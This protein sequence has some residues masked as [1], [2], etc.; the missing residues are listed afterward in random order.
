MAISS[1][2]V[3]RAFKIQS[4]SVDLLSGSLKIDYLKFSNQPTDYPISLINIS[5]EFHIKAYPETSSLFGVFKSGSTEQVTQNNP[6][7]IAPT[8]SRDVVVRVVANLNNQP[9]SIQ[10]ES[11]KFT[12]NAMTKR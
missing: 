12:L 11:V 10:L 6:I 4:G 7:I 5:G 3:Q 2:D 9:E 8:Q 1:T